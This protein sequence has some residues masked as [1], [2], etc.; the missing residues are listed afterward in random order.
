MVDDAGGVR[1]RRIAAELARLRAHAGG[2]GG[3]AMRAAVRL[4]VEALERA[5]NKSDLK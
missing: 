2:A 1:A 4:R 3:D 5:L